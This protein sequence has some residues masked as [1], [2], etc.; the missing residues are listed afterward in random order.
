M[1]LVLYPMLA[2]GVSAVALG[3][4]GKDKCF[5]DGCIAWG[6]ACLA[7]LVFGLLGIAGAFE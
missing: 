3:I 5:M 6:V 1:R 2:I 4:F 7:C